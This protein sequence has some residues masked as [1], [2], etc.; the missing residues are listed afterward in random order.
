MRKQFGSVTAVP[1]ELGQRVIARLIWAGL[2]LVAYVIQV[3]GTAWALNNY[4]FD[5]LTVINGIAVVYA[6]G[7]TAWN[8][9]T[10]ATRSTTV[11]GKFRGFHFVK[12][13]TGEDAKALT[14]AK[15]LV[16]GAFEGITL[17][18]GMIS[19]LVSYRD[20]QHWLDR[21]FKVTAV[22]TESVL[23]VGAWAGS[24]AG[25]PDS[26]QPRVMP[27][28]MPAPSGSPHPPATSVPSGFDPRRPESTA[29]PVQ[30]AHV[31]HQA[32]GQPPAE[33]S[34]PEA[35]VQ[36][37]VQASAS[38]EAQPAQP[39]FAPANPW[40]LPAQQPM[41]Q[42]EPAPAQFP[43][44]Q[45]APQPPPQAPV[46]APQQVEPPM[47]PI[48]AEAASQSLLDDK[49]VIDADIAAEHAPAV[50]LDDGQVVRIDTPVVLGR[51]PS[52]PAAYPQAR[53]VSVTDESMRMSKTH[54]VLIPLEDGVGVL[55]AGATN[56]VHFEV[57]GDRTRI[58]A[59]EVHPL[60]LATVLHFG[61]RTLQVSP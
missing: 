25:A 46:T 55:D 32:P 20:G 44:A 51:N 56:G 12:D 19:Y 27:V 41:G 3:A 58:P 30:E 61:G 28:T 50:V 48:G 8:L 59:G 18:L 24:Q 33:V 35:P 15:Y 7:L 10:M 22:G 36:P 16:E 23:P 4:A 40:A 5:A 52:A 21:A 14:L 29:Q 34:P 49:T 43:V 17:G 9:I 45:P 53:C 1:V 6:L 54:L 37:N 2:V 39:A 57:D 42:P 13:D 11:G 26:Q 38:S 47:A 31:P 60:S